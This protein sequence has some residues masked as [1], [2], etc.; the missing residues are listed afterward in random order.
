M[1]SCKFLYYVQYVYA[2]ISILGKTVKVLI[3]NAWDSMSHHWS[4]YLHR[5][6]IDTFKHM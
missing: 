2:N 5:Y 6:G 1:T 3:H 4:V